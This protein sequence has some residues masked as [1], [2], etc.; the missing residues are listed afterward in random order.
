M[1]SASSTGSCVPA[2]EPFA[3]GLALD[4]RHGEPELAGGLARVVDRQ[5]V[6]VLE[7]GGEPDLALE[8]LGPE[9]RGSSGCRTLRATGRSCLTSSREVHRGHAAAAELALD[10]VAIAQGFGR[11]GAAS[12][13]GPLMVGGLSNLLLGNPERQSG[14]VDY[15][16]RRL[17]PGAY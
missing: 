15:I 3:K 1:R 16:F 9:R 14:K 2:V 4:V 17:G 10:R 5:D 13:I 8:A 6:G 12:A 11:A 7:P